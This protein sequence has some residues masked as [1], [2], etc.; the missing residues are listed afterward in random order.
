[1]LSRN[2]LTTELA[3]KSDGFREFVREHSSELH[4]YLQAVRRLEST[5]VDEVERIIAASVDTVGAIPS[6]E[7]ES[8]S[9]TVPFQHR[10]N[11]HQEARGW[12]AE[13]LSDRTTFAA[14][15]S[16]VYAGKETSLPIA[17]VQIGWFENPHNAESLYHKNAVFEILTPADLFADQDEPMNP[18]IRVEERRYLG[19]IG[20]VKEFVSAKSGWESR[21]ERMPVAFFD[22][23]LLV[24]FSQKG[25]QKSFLAATLE[26]VQTSVQSRVPVVGYVDRSFSRDMLSLL[27]LFGASKNAKAS[28]VYDASILTANST[29]GRVLQHWGDRTCFFYSKRRG[30]EAFI[31]PSTGQASVGFSYLQTA[32]ESA[33]VR[34]DLP[35][36]I[37]ESGLLEQVVDV[38]LA[39]CVVGLGYPYV[40]ESADQT[41]V[42]SPRDR[43]VFFRTLQEFASHEK[44]DF[45]VA[46]KDASKAR[47]R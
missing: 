4:T 33:P 10:W 7:I 3:R 15:G 16:Q 39:E 27:D 41:A 36:W 6:A 8:G 38:V 20:R 45:S 31:D 32:R 18:D 9:L 47:R 5:P 34:I 28:G 19:E 37:Y 14:D 21:G 13:V 43:E 29:A 44:L 35:A 2:A 12:A 42:I 24:P 1:M 30:L 17:G 22:N 40:L 11:N 26:L 46:R 23:P 25:L